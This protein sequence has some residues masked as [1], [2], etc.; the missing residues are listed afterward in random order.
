VNDRL[1]D[2]GDEINGRVVLEQTLDVCREISLSY[3]DQ[4]T[5]QLGST[6]GEIHNRSRFVYKLDGVNQEWV[7]TTEQ[8]PNINFMSL[9]YGDYTL[10]VRMLNDDGTIGDDEATLEIHIA[11]PIWR[12]RWAMLLYVLLVLAAVW[13][14]RRWF[15]RRQ[16]ERDELEHQRRELEKQQWMSEMRRQM[17]NEGGIISKPAYKEEKLSFKP[18][19]EELV[20]FVKQKVEQYAVP[21]EKRTKL[22]FAS[23]LNRITMRFDPA[24]MARLLDILL[25]NAVKFSP[26]GSRVK[27]SLSEASKNIELQV[28]DRGLGIP[29]E[30][31]AHMF[32]ATVD[33]G[34]GLDVVM[35]I[36]NLHGGT[37]SA[38]D[39]PDGGTVF[40]VLLPID[41]PEEVPIE[42]AVIIED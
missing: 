27:V 22:Q 21:V 31:R 30:A 28:A 37:V 11:T 4:F 7:K 33:P 34:I 12:A 1:V 35:R 32:D 16:K 41:A 3:R 2:V 23:S 24:L 9:R 38:D 19:T 13:W 17:E 25:G 6:S 10:R 14:W 36:A 8:N 20:G 18:V 26:S 29:E 5:I 15:L 40:T 39:N 42:E